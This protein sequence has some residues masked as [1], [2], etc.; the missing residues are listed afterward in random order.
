MATISDI[1]KKC[2]VSNTTV[3]RVLNYDSSL[4]IAEDKRRLILET[5]EEMSYVTPRR[6]RKNNGLNGSPLKLA[7]VHWYTTSKELEDTYYL[8]IRHGIEKEATLQQI[9]LVEIF[10]N[11]QERFDLDIING[12]PGIIALGKFSKDE[13]KQLATLKKHV[14][15][16][17]SSPDD[18]L[19]DSVVIDAY[20]AVRDV[21]NYCVDGGH[22]E[23]GYIGGIELVGPDKEQ[24]EEYRE[25]YFREILTDRGLYQSKYFYVDEMSIDSGYSMAKKALSADDLPTVFFIASDAMAVGVLK[26]FYE[27]GIKVPND[28]S[29]ISFNDIA[30]SNF[31][32]PPLTTVKIEKEFMGET[33]VHLM[34]ERIRENRLISKKVMIP[35]EI[36]RR[37]SFKKIAKAS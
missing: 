23:I 6:R 11:E 16:I 33:A 2:K 21:V 19:F 13:V 31:T 12:C 10:K 4:M 32:I 27:S 8:A 26:A 24:A 1:A 9:E 17:G 5:A 36:I 7:L 29:I 30:I 22:R 18:K 3:S 28:V 37:A 14:V 20:R 15:F 25:R 34:L 35:T